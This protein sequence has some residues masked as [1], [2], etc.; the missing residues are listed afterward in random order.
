MPVPDFQ[1]I[2]LPLLS[3]HADAQDHSLREAITTLADTFNLTQ[4][5]R[6]ELLPSG[7]QA[8]FDNRVGWARTH[9][10]KA[11]L[12]ESP[13]RGKMRITSR[14]HEVLGRDLERVDMA[15]LNEFPEFRAF[16]LST[17]E[18]VAPAQPLERVIEAGATP[19][20]LLEES[21]RTLQNELADDLLK[22]VMTC[23]WQFFEALVVELLLA[24]GYGGSR[25]EAGQ[26]FQAG[27]D[28]GVDGV[29]KEDRLGLRV[30]YVQAKRWQ[31]N[32][33]R[34]DVQAFAGSLIG[35]GA[36]RGVFMT[37]SSFSPGARDY[38]RNV[39]TPKIILVDGPE[40]AQLMIEHNVGV[41]EAQRYVVKRL[42]LDYFEEA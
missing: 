19:T 42:D 27:N 12:L 22:R 29:I 39:P 21:Y 5:E 40:L 33:Q 26:A 28:E 8:R 35:K 11:G 14:G 37:T 31:N 24:M 18:T 38:A 23:S 41:S 6:Q 15:L 25:E 13:E 2:M 32:V 7:R 3:L 36:D 4:E 16:R 34:Q 1:T 20:E 9:L 10:T 30:I 17:A